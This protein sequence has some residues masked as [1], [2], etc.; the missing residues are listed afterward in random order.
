MF[1][2][3]DFYAHS[4]TSKEREMVGIEAKAIEEIKI[5]I[6]SSLL[7]AFSSGDLIDLVND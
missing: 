3:A 5:G 4:R 7:H 6:G 1:S 2:E